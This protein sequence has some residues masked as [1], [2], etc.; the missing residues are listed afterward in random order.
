MNFQTTAVFDFQMATE[1]PVFTHRL[2]IISKHVL[3]AY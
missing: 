1:S 3:L 2:K